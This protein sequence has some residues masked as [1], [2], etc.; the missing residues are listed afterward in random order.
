MK[1]GVIAW[2]N[3]PGNWGDILQSYMVLNI[4]REMNI[5][6]EDIIF[7]HYH[8]I[9][10]YAGE[11]KLLL[12]MVGYF[13]NIYNVDIFPLP[14]NIIPFFWGFHCT[15]EKVLQYLKPEYKYFG[16]RDLET[17]DAISKWFFDQDVKVYM[18][19]CVTMLL[20]KRENAIVKGKVF[21]VDIRE[22]L[23]PYIPRYLLEEA[24]EQTQIFSVQGT[25][26]N[27]IKE[28]FQ[29]IEQWIYNYAAQAKLVITSRVH[30]A[31]PCTALGIP[32]IV[33][34][35]YNNDTDRFSG[36]EELFHVYKPHEYSDIDWEPHVKD[37]SKLKQMIAMNL[38]NWINL[39]KN[40]QR[41]V[42]VSNELLANINQVDEIFKKNKSLIVYRG[43]KFSYL[44]QKQK[45]DFYCRRQEYTNILE[46]LLG[47]KIND[48]TII[49]WGAGDKG[50]YM[51][52]RYQSALNTCKNFFYV[53]GNPLKYQRNIYGR[54]IFSPDIIKKYN[55]N[56]ICVIV[57]VKE[58]YGKNV[59]QIVER[60]RNEFELEEEKN[61]LILDKIDESARMAIDDIGMSCTLM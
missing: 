19:G 54:P 24:V 48:I 6:M 26:E 15:D 9:A 37:F 40:E 10:Q 52:R 61:F 7:I 50:F 36:Y 2:G 58:Y 11:E 30:V 21:L 1:Y 57:A 35:D 28:T 56:E 14:N 3:K 13:N 8:Q 23:R 22:S 59:Q 51:A 33:T 47:K 32:V 39:Y 38:K 16:C 34:A 43:E 60:L 20:P 41:A 25:E 31:I 55:P 44:S 5:E 27:N 29:G 45:E 46:Y 12:P 17:V 18:S 4:Y 49:I 42:K 53:D